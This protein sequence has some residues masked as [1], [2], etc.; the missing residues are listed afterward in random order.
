MSRRHGRAPHPVPMSSVDTPG[1]RTVA[2]ARAIDDA[3]TP[4]TWSAASGAPARGVRSWA[5]TQAA[6]ASSGRTVMR[7]STSSPSM[8]TTPPRRQLFDRHGGE[9]PQRLV[10]R[11]GHADDEQA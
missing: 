2:P 1:R 11:H 5:T 7:A 3:L 10:E 6:G 8:P 4:M 9:D